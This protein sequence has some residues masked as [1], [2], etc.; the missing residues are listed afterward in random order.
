MSGDRQQAR[1][2]VL[3]HRAAAPTHLFNI[4]EL[5]FSDDLF[6]APLNGPWFLLGAATKQRRNRGG[7]EQAL[8][9]Q[10]VLISPELFASI[11]DKLESIGNVFRSMGTPGGVLRGAGIKNYS[12]VP[13][14]RFE[15]P[16]T[17]A[18]GEPLVFLRANTTGSEF[19]I[20]PDLWMFLELEEKAVGTRIW[21]DPRH[22]EDVIVPR[23]LNDGQVKT[24]EIRTEYLLR[25]LRARQLSLLVGHYRDS[26]FFNPPKSAIDTFIKSDVV[27]GTAEQGVKAIFQNWGLRHGITDRKQFL[28]RRLH[29]WF[30]VRPPDLSMQDPWDEMPSF[31]PYSFTLPTAAG[32]VAPARWKH[33]P[34]CDNGEFAGN[35]TDFMDNVYFRQEVLSKYEGAAGFEVE[36]N[37]SV[38]CRHYWSL[39]RSTFRLGNDLLETHIGDFAEGVPFEEWPHWKQYAVEPPSLETAKALAQE[40]RIPD[41]VNSVMAALNRLNAAFAEL[42]KSA[43]AGGADDVWCGSPASLAC[44]QLKWV[45]PASADDDEFLKRATLASTLFLDGLLP[46]PM[47]KLLSALGSNLHRSFDKCP[48]SLGSRNL[49]QRVALAAALISRLQPGA[50]ELPT[51]IQQGEGKASNSSPELQAELEAV[52]KQMREAFAPLAFLYDLRTHGGLAHPPQ[53]EQ[54][55]KAAASLG[56]PRENWHRSDYLQLLKLIAGSVSSISE[57]LEAGAETFGEITGLS[58]HE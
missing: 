9:R 24:V 27:L 30:E 31:D 43:G 17:A 54:A 3:I 57:Q 47:R 52:Y 23:L 38:H 49:L 40:T 2:T 15:F 58:A 32:P 56:L 35:V 44:R 6:T 39:S 13:F 42:A 33:L 51:L 37:G 11:F 41:A 5:D 22:G 55:G 20:N 25:Y 36:D 18:A 4:R 50:A 7:I 46:S 21:W 29:L 28:Q 16:F 14:H 10:S 53:K 34:D 8:S 1:R 26:H 48:Q 12:Y 19:F 45:Y